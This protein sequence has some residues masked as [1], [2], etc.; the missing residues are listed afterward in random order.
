MSQQHMEFD[1]SQRERPGASYTGYEGV[2]PYNN[3]SS[4]TYGQKLSGHE[5]SRGPTAAQRLAL[6]IVSFVLWIALFL[7][8]AAI[9][10]S[11]IPP[12]GPGGYA[13]SISGILFPFLIIGFLIFSA[14]V[15]LVNVLFN[16]KR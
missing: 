6:A 9:M 3:Y 12:F 1:E 5:A 11:Y 13:Q 2:P 10:S 14:I 4:N 15:I 8:I 16:R 7:I